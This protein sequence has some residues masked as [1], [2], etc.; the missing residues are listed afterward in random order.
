MN[1]ARI[2]ECFMQAAGFAAARIPTFWAQSITLGNKWYENNGYYKFKVGESIDC[3]SSRSCGYGLN[4]QG[5]T[6]KGNEKNEPFG[7]TYIIET[8]EGEMQ[9]HFKWNIENHFKP[10]VPDAKPF[11]PHR[12]EL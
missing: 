1:T 4:P 10:A 3:K 6:V 7:D 2:R 5:W 12:F 9:K 8:A 11:D